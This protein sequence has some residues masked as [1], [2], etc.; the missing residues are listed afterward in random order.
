MTTKQGRDARDTLVGPDLGELSWRPG[1]NPSR[2][3]SKRSEVTSEGTVR[4]ENDLGK[5]LQAINGPRPRAAE[6]RGA[7]EV[8]LI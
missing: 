8:D 6:V 5:N 3:E 1:L 2:L 7:F 4:D